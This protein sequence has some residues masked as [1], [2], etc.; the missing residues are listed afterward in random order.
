MEPIRSLDMDDLARRYRAPLA[1]YFRGRLGAAADV[2]DLV[3]E[4]FLRLAARRDGGDVEAVENYLFTVASSVMNDSFR[5]TGR[6]G[7]AHALFDE[8]LHGG[9]DFSPERV[10][11][12]QEQLA[13]VEIALHELPERTRVI[14]V[15]NRFEDMTYAQI[16]RRLQVSV[17]AV[18]K[19]MSKALAHLARRGS[20][21]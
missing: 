20:P 8:R 15:L 7:G 3:Q 2:D 11:I 10:F 13:V 18:E 17:S 14:F 21:R 16:A 9:E 6:R 12:A 19:H 4:V 5:R 1:R